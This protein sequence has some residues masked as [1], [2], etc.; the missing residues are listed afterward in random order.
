MKTHNKL[1]RDLIPAI[2]QRSGK[3]AVTRILSSEEYI[4]ALHRKLDEEAAELHESGSLE[5][6]ADVLEVLLA[7]C[8][9]A[10][11][12]REELESVRAAKAAERGGFRERIFLEEVQ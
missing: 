1:V 9:A 3:T 10:G 6:M 4:T 11:H 12:T 8:A 5:E 7:I 2:I